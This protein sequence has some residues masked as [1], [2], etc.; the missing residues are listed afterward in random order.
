MCVYVCMYIYI[1]IYVCVGVCVRARVS[2][3]VCVRARVRAFFMYVLYSA[4]LYWCLEHCSFNGI[5]CWMQ[6]LYAIKLPR[7]VRKRKKRPVYSYTQ[8]H[9]RIP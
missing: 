8:K 2:V 9:T 7:F 1:Y 6:A 4:F 3:C 5:S